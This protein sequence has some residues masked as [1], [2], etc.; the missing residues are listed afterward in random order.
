MVNEYGDSII[1]FINDTLQT[2]PVIETKGLG[3]I[4]K[5]IVYYR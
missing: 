4:S 5:S 1:G 2:S 3:Y